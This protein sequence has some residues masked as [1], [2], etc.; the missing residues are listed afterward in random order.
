MKAP[1]S[2]R[3]RPPCGRPLLNVML[4]GRVT[5]ELIGEHALRVKI[6]DAEA[7]RLGITVR[8]LPPYSPAAHGKWIEEILRLHEQYHH[9]DL[10]VKERIARIL[11]SV[12]NKGSKK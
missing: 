11:E 5:D 12:K 1:P 4:G 7:A 2:K 3:R 8:S 9:G 10:S 6:A